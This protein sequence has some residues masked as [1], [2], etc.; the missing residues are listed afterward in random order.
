MY[1]PNAEYQED[2]N[3]VEPESRSE[4]KRKAVALEN[5]GASLVE[6]SADRFDKLPLT[7]ELRGAI[8]ELR[9]LTNL[10]A[11]RRQIQY[12]G[13]IMRTEDAVPIV[14][15]IEAMRSKSVRS[16]ASFRVIEAMRDRLV[17]EGEA[18][19]DDAMAAHPS[20]DRAT[21]AKLVRRAHK[22]REEGQNIAARALFRYLRDLDGAA[23]DAG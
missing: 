8:V 11:R 2:P 14:E 13:R 6:L 4:K 16:S 17:V 5:L 3:A 21:L 7:D 23:G 19:L 12:I 18:A 20:A 1:E 9:R 10:A 22:E 15:A